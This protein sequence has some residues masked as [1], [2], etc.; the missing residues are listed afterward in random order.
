MSKIKLTSALIIAAAAAGCTTT[1]GPKMDRQD[2][3]SG[4]Q[5]VLTLNAKGSTFFR[6]A[7]DSEGFYWKY[8][9][10]DARLTNSNHKYAGVV[11]ASGIKLNSGRE[12]KLTPLVSSPRGYSDLPDTLF[13]LHSDE[14]SAPEFAERISAKGGMPLAKCSPSQRDAVLK[15]PFTARFVFYRHP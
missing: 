12:W 2:Y 10:S 13:E 7:Y 9:R 4:T 11:T 3:L 15:V 1:T 5:V 8:L 14:A 6:C